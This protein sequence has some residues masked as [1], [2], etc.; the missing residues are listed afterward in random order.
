VDSGPKTLRATRST[1]DEPALAQVE[2]EYLADRDVR[3]RRQERAS[4]REAALDRHDIKRFSAQPREM[5]PG[6]P[7]GREGVIG[8]HA[9]QKYSGRVGRSATAKALD[10]QVVRL[11]VIAHIRHAETPYDALLARGEA[12]ESTRAQVEPAMARVLRQ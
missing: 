12:R 7:P 5:F 2:A 3:A 4:A 1:V 11:A 6:C 9:C 8:E 10:E